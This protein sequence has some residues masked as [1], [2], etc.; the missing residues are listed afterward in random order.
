[1][2]CGHIIRIAHSPIWP[3][4]ID[5]STQR[6]IRIIK[7]HQ[8]PSLLLTSPRRLPHQPYQHLRMSRRGRKRHYR[9]DVSRY[10][11]RPDLT[12][13]PSVFRFLKEPLALHYVVFQITWSTYRDVHPCSDI[14]DQQRL[15]CT[16]KLL[17]NRESG[18]C[19]SLVVCTRSLDMPLRLQHCSKS[20]YCCLAHHDL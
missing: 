19:G 12:R 1:M 6:V 17:T 13:K 11:G 3:R 20:I 8:T 16:S 14:D 7:E 18:F 15:D 2:E 4:D 5:T 10:K 9:I